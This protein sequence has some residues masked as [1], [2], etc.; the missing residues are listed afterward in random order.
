MKKLP[1]VSVII[2]TFNGEKFL[3][4]S[5]LSATSQTY[6]NLEIIIFDNKSKDKTFSIVKGIKDKKIRYYKS[7]KYLKLYA[8]RNEAIKKAKGEYLA[9]LDSDDWWKSTKIEKQIH[10]AIRKNYD[11]VYSNYIIFNQKTKTK[12]IYTKKKLPEGFIT[13]SLLNKYDVAVQTV[14]VKKKVFKNKMFNKRYEIIGDFDF[15]VKLSL[16]KNFGSIQNPLAFYRLHGSNYSIKKMYLHISEMK[17]WIKNNEGRFK[18]RDFN[19]GA[20]KIYLK[21]LKIKN[22][23]N[24]FV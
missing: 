11:L 17:H 22:L 14:L 24:K 20:Q 7:K 9:F 4:K 15:F 21:K 2:N 3:R 13:Q 19:I 5:I 18:K 12:K 8:A 6:K 10:H 16:D 23:L 1:L